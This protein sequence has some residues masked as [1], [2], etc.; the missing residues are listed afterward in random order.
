LQG[1]PQKKLKKIKKKWSLPITQT[2]K[3]F[4]GAENSLKIID[5][6]IRPRSRFPCIAC[7]PELP[8][9]H[10]KQ[11]SAVPPLFLNNSCP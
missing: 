3:D 11:F 4:L 5:Y 1:I 6:P 10:P 2:G 8:E 7:N 9:T